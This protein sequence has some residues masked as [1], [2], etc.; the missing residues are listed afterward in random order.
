MASVQA[1]AFGGSSKEAGLLPLTAKE[2]G[3]GSFAATSAGGS[4]VL[5]A[6]MQAAAQH[7]EPQPPQLQQ[8]PSQRELTFAAL[9]ESAWAA[10]TAPNTFSICSADSTRCDKS[11]LPE[12]ARGAARRWSAGDA[13]AYS[14]A[15]V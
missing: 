9:A 12:A 1:K 5:S 2:I 4:V 13:G 8:A 7:P 14:C 11:A 10:I 15:T 6:I 3:R